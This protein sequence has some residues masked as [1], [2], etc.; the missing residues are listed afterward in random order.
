M[1]FW[2][3]IIL[4]YLISK[5]TIK[6]TR[7]K[8]NYSNS[9]QTIIFSFLFAGFSLFSCQSTTTSTENP[10]IRIADEEKG[11]VVSFMLSNVEDD[12]NGTE[13]TIKASINEKIVEITKARNCEV[14]EI[15]DYDSKDIPLDATWACA[16]WWAGAGNDFYAK[17]T[18]DKL[19]I[20]KKDVYEEMKSEDE[21]WELFKTLE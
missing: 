6:F 7:M 14:V 21:K 16:C 15:T 8:I 4:I 20:Y 18:T 11:L 10:D 19:E 13:S 1:Y 17:K 3:D 5:L 12:I 9:V 2:K